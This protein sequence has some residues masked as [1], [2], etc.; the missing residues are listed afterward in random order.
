MYYSSAQRVPSFFAFRL[1]GTCHRGSNNRPSNTELMDCW[2]EKQTRMTQT[3]TH[4]LILSHWINGDL[5]LVEDVRACVVTKQR[6]MQHR[7]DWQSWITYWQVYILKEQL[8]I[9]WPEKKLH[10][11]WQSHHNPL[12]WCSFFLSL[13]THM[14]SHWCWLAFQHS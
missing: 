14:Q 7:D 3:R 10:I 2:A 1:G 8:I 13:K 6:L 12:F 9:G 4:F 5:S 11:T